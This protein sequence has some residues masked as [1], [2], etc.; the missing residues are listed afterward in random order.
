MHFIG[1]LPFTAMLERNVLISLSL[2]PSF[3]LSLS[4]SLSPKTPPREIKKKR[5]RKI[6]LQ[7]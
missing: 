7:K 3:S 2:S 4:L 5:L 1:V 6:F